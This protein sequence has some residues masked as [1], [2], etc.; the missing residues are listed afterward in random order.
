MKKET[1]MK[2]NSKTILDK[3]LVS[4]NLLMV[5]NIQASGKMDLS[6]EKEH[7]IRLWKK[8]HMKAT[9]KKNIVKEKEKLFTELVIYLKVHGGKT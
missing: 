7:I 9:L 4:K 5:I 1:D 3:D 2:D 8:K 6:K